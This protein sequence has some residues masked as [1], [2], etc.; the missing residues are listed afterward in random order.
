MVIPCFDPPCYASAGPE[1]SLSFY[2]ELD[3]RRP[4]FSEPVA[5]EIR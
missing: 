3:L 4:G 5:H 2:L 1:A